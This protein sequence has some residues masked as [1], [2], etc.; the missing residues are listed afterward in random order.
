MKQFKL[1]F[2]AVVLFFGATQISNAQKV[3]HINT[4]ELVE[5]MPA[6]KAAES[7]LEKLQKTYDTE[8]KGMAK[9]LEAK[10]K[11]YDVEAESKTDE[12]N[13]KRFQEVQ[14]MRNSIQAYQQDAV[15]Q[16]DKKR[17]DLFQPILDQAR[18]AI[19]KVA[20]AQG[21]EYVLDSTTGGGLLL[22]DGTDL[23]P[24]VK[25]DLGI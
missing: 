13:Q 19:Q 20:R 17:V 15:Q 22:A 14:G 5:A 24:L 1:L 18:A 11:Q 8:I 23:L 3:A 10:M 7:Q 4:Q 6:M 12:E 2:V 21:I 16:L 9:E 25:K